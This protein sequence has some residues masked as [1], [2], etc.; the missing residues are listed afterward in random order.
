M[1]KP[2]PR[3]LF[4]IIPLKNISSRIAGKTA[5]R[6]VKIITSPISF[7]GKLAPLTFPPRLSIPFAMTVFKN[8]KPKNIDMDKSKLSG[9]YLALNFLTPQR[10]K[11]FVFNFL[12]KKSITAIMAIDEKVAQTALKITPSFCE[13]AKR[14]A[15]P[16]IVIKR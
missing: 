5:K 3:K 7:R 10:L 15:C 1:I 9:K 8:P 4:S 13:N 14:M 6:M 11:M 12:E 2:P 16:T